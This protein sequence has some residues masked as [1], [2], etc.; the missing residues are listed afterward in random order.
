MPDNESVDIHQLITFTLDRLHREREEAKQQAIDR[1]RQ[2]QQRRVAKI[3]A[4]MMHFEIACDWARQHFPTEGPDGLGDDPKFWLFFGDHSRTMIVQAH[5][6]GWPCGPKHVFAFIGDAWVQQEPIMLGSI[7]EV[8][9][10]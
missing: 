6:N 7:L 8:G 10:S 2:Q 1:A 3:H 9:E 4:E 5:L